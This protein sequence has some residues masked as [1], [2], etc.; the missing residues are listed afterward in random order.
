[1]VAIHTGEAVAVDEEMVAPEDQTE[2]EVV[3][4]KIPVKY[5]SPATSG[6]TADVTADGENSFTFELTDE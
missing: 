4:A 6:F 2:E 1:M 3:E 5:T